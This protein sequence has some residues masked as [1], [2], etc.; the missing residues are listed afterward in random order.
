MKR[1]EW[2]HMSENE[3]VASNRLVVGK[4]V[5]NKMHKTI[6]VRI[7]RLVEHPKYGKHIRQFTKLFAHDENNECAEGD[8]VAI[9]Q[10]RPFSKKKAWALVN[11]IEKTV[12]S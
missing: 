7:E 10:S 4:V 1:F 9:K 6:V 3:T 5:S 2:I 8:V 11:I 12:V